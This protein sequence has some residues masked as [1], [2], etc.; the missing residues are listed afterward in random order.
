D[1]SSIPG[2]PD[3]HEPLADRGRAA[4]LART[5]A[6]DRT[7][8]RPAEPAAA[9]RLWNVPSGLRSAGRP[10]RGPR[11]PSASVRARR[12]AGLGAKPRVTPPGPDAAARPHRPG[13]VR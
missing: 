7:A 11:G 1:V 5:A 6:D 4:G 2:Y 9:E 3:G 10:Q 12:R 8:E 13:G